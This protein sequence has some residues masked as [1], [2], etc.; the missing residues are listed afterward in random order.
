MGVRIQVEIAVGQGAPQFY[1]VCSVCSDLKTQI[2]SLSVNLR[3]HTDTR[4][5]KESVDTRTGQRERGARGES[6]K[7]R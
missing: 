7:G 5:E 3:Y 1:C 4:G 6:E 2:G